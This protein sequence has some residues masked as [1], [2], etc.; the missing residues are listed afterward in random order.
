MLPMKR[1]NINLSTTLSKIM[2][3]LLVV[4]LVSVSS[5]IVVSK[6]ADDTGTS[7]NSTALTGNEPA[8][9]ET[10]EAQALNN[11]SFM[12]VQTAHSGSLVPVEGEDNRYILTLEGVSPQTICFSDRPERVVV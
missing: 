3:V 1:C 10:E 5:I 9:N 4:A 11:S 12:F 7:N 6:A 8:Q 2:A